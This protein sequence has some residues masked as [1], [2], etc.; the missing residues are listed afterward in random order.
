M[1][2]RRA[3]LQGSAGV[4]GRDWQCAHGLKKEEFERLCCMLFDGVTEAMMAALFKEVD[5]D[6]NGE[7]DFNEFIT[8][9]DSLGSHLSILQ[10]AKPGA[11]GDADGDGG[12]TLALYR[13]VSPETAAKL[14][15]GRLENA[16]S[17]ASAHLNEM[18]AAL[19]SSKEGALE[20]KEVELR[21]AMAQRG[22]R[23]RRRSAAGGKKEGGSPG[24]GRR[25]SIM[26]RTGEPTTPRGVR[27][28][29]D[30]KEGWESAKEAVALAVEPL[31]P[32]DP[33]RALDE[34]TRA[35]VPKAHE[36][37]LRDAATALMAKGFMIDEVA[38]LVGALYRVNDA[39]LAKRARGRQTAKHYV[40]EAWE[41]LLRHGREF[42]TAATELT[43]ANEAAE[44]EVR[45]AKRKAR[46]A[47]LTWAGAAAKAK[48]QSRV[49][50]GATAQ[51]G[52]ARL[53]DL[54]KAAAIAKKK[55]KAMHDEHE[56]LVHG[57]G[58]HYD[59]EAA[60]AA[61][62][63]AAHH[64]RELEAAPCRRMLTLLA[65]PLVDAGQLKAIFVAFDANG[66]GLISEAELESVFKLLNPHRR[67]AKHTAETAAAKAAAPDKMLKVQ[68]ERLAKDAQK[69]IKEEIT[70]GSLKAVNESWDGLMKRVTKLLPSAEAEAEA[71]RRKRYDGMPHP[72]VLRSLGRHKPEFGFA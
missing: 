13:P 53:L 64:L 60:A 22:R 68:A 38:T 34:R 49:A 59:E 5:R 30:L 54:T 62:M 28:A 15:A 32:F 31:L 19:T 72:L 39:G 58:Q 4:P 36:A 52:A 65:R 18:L 16:A 21:D 26:T 27:M 24:M 8:L 66:D 70:S 67:L 43:D 29:R 12:G 2:Q 50:G 69:A 55:E 48:A 63:H 7:I 25:S 35:L 10:Q 56:S 37:K 33:L 41:V 3:S 45:V 40:T 42:G 1:H 23:G 17:G 46:R 11:D 6:M 51:T 57:E 14:A 20:A 9:I 71:E 61:A 44:E 47:S